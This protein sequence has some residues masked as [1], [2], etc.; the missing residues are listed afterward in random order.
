MQIGS[1]ELNHPVMKRP[2]WM[3]RFGIALMAW[4]VLPGFERTCP[5]VEVGKY[6]FG[7][8]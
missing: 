3:A 4:A 5:W 2:L 1:F 6:L 7:W 8:I